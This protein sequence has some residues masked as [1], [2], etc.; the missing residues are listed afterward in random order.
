VFSQKRVRAVLSSGPPA[1]WLCALLW[2][3]HTPCVSGIMRIL[4]TG[5]LA[6]GR[7]VFHDSI[8]MNSLLIGLPT[9]ANI[10]LSVTLPRGG[11]ASG[12]AGPAQGQPAATLHHKRRQPA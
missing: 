7:G 6:F 5:G 1:G 9:G 10:G 4:R 3:V 12:E 8:R 2:R 11:R